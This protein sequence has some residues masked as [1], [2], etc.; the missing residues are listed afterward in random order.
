MAHLR[1]MGLKCLGYIDDGLGGARFKDEAIR[2]R[3][4]T[5]T[6]YT[7]LGWVINKEKSDLV[8]GRRK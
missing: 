5:V 4:M 7:Q 8:V 2:L 6:I 3:Q 1:S